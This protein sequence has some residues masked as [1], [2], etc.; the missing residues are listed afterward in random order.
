MLQRQVHRTIKVTWSSTTVSRL[1]H[2]TRRCQEPISSLPGARRSK[3]MIIAQRLQTKA[4]PP[5]SSYSSTVPYPSRGRGSIYPR[6][7][8]YSAP[9]SHIVNWLTWMSITRS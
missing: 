8:S 9:G 5:T 4:S 1:V 3:I 7:V 6:C 2:C